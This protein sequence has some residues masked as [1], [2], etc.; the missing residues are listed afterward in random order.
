M[1]IGKIKEEIKEEEGYRN[2]MY[3]DHLGFSTIGY[4]HLVLPTDKFK[5]GVKYSQKELEK[6]FDYDFAIAKQDAESLTKDLDVPEE[7]TEILLHMC[8][9]LGKPKVMKFKKMFAAL[10]KK[11]FVTAGFEMEDSLWCKKHTPARAL[12][13][14]EKMKKLT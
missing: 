8:F 5:E 12:R 10:Q 6:V 2:S 4:G 3:R 14:S 11:D 1:N 9:Q 13:L 7:V